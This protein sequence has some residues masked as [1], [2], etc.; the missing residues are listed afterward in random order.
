M[1]RRAA[2]AFLR[3]QNAT[4]LRGPGG[5]T[6]VLHD[7][8]LEIWPGQ[9]TAIL[10]PNGSGKS[11]LIKLLTQ[12]YRPLAR[13]G[14]DAVVELFGRDRWD[15]FELRRLMGIVSPDVQNN[16]AAGEEGRSLSG[17]EVVVS[18]FFA[19]RGVQPYQSVSQDMWKAGRQALALLEATHLAAK[20]VPEMSTG[21]ARR[22]LIARALVHDPPALL[23]DEPT[24]G[25]DMVATARF[26]GTLQR[27]A[28]RGKTIIVVT[29]HLH[30]IIPE[31]QRVV[32]LR[33]GTVHRDG[34]KSDVLTGANLSDAFGAPVRVEAHASGFYS[35]VVPTVAE[36]V[37]P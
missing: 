2:A 35:M 29:H 23:L 16:L 4:V 31:V 22:V 9:H 8:S 13:P 34:P 33:A 19:T 10:G 3:I 11:S 28:R 27:L 17:L 36:P 5:R 12:E 18:G 37:L 25:L 24:T 26:L 7:L 32:L 6:P 15:V 1:H 30:E 20:P 21:E 14:Q